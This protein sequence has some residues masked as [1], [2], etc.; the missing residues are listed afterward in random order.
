M[1][2][3][4][5]AVPAPAGLRRRSKLLSCI[6]LEYRILSLTR[7]A[8]TVARRYAKKKR[9]DRRRN[10]MHVFEVWAPYARTMEVKIGNEKF[11]MAGKERGWWSAEVAPAGPG[12]DYG[13]VID[14]LEPALPDPRSRWQPNG[15][16]GESR[17]GGD[18]A[19]TWSDSGWQAP[20][21][22]SALIYELHLGTFTPEGT[23]TAAESHLD[24]LKDLGVTHVELMPIANFPANRDGGNDGWVLY[25][26]T[27]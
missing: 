20:P 15:V 22:S 19:F 26:L 9:S 27:S 18:T 13:F 25:A 8:G 2:P 17:V 6:Q 16:H 24:Y 23:L 11:A 4:T 1:P 3:S 12:A 14:G 21:L 7:V 5:W 10:G